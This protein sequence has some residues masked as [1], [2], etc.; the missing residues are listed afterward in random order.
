M[1]GKTARYRTM[2]RAG[3]AH[4]PR[5]N[6]VRVWLSFDAYI[7]D[8]E[9]YLTAIREA[10]SILTEERLHII[11][12]YLIGWFGL[13]SFGGFTVECAQKSMYPLYEKYLRDC[14]NAI[15][16]SD[17]LM[18]DIANEPFNNV[19]GNQPVFDRIACFMEEMIRVLRT[20]RS[21]PARSAAISTT[22]MK[23]PTPSGS[24]RRWTS[25]ACTRTIS[26]TS[27]CLISPRKRRSC[28]IISRRSESRISSRNAAGARRA[29]K[30]AARFLNPS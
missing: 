20:V 12:I 19:Y 27:P 13:P 29:K 10:C 26:T 6:T 1:S 25:S 9:R 8:R 11:P 2:I 30:N 14:L 15:R 22:G 5:M 4:F 23:S 21:P 16:E 18:H 24:L 28:S 7:S 3:K 17:I